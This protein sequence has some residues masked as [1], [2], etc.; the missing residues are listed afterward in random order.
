MDFIR[1]GMIMANLITI[2]LK[3]GMGI[4]KSIAFWNFFFTISR[5][6]LNF[7]HYKKIFR[8]SYSLQVATTQKLQPFQVNGW[9]A[10]SGLASVQVCNN[11]LYRVTSSRLAKFTNIPQQMPTFQSPPTK[12]TRPKAKYYNIYMV[13]YGPNHQVF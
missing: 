10:F 9:V 4:G 6:M 2:W 12:A 3:I 11:H 13:A 1:I 5:T 7:I 8:I